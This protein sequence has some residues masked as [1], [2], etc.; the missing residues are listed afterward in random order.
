M[1]PVL[2]PYNVAELIPQLSFMA[3]DLQLIQHLPQLQ[4][5]DF[6]V[7]I[8]YV[9]AGLYWRWLQN[10]G[11]SNCI[12]YHIKNAPNSQQHVKITLQRM[13]FIPSVSIS[14]WVPPNTV[15]VII[16]QQQNTKERYRM[17][18]ERCKRQERRENNHI[19]HHNTT[20][21]GT[22]HSTSCSSTHDI[23]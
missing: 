6:L 3:Q 21:T 11:G 18:D 19:T 17:R 5:S 2:I 4:T 9:Y 16:H 13:L 7:H 1:D 22:R 14:R 8:V 20:I 12:Q 10:I 15:S 23:C